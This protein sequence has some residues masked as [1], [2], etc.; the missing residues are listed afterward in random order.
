MPQR[1]KMKTRRQLA[2][3][4][5]MQP[6]GRGGVE[7]QQLNEA[8]ATGGTE[9]MKS[10]LADISGRDLGDSPE[11]RELRNILATL[12]VKLGK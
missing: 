10:L 11:D 8:I 1:K 2:D 12:R 4:I 9:A 7:R 5:H 3:E 6:E